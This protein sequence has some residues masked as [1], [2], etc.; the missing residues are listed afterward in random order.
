M[1][2][3]LAVIFL[4]PGYVAALDW[5]DTPSTA[6]RKAQEE[7]KDVLYLYTSSKM[8]EP[9]RLWLEA[10]QERNKDNDPLNDKF[11]VCPIELPDR[12]VMGNSGKADVV[13]MALKHGVNVVPT[14]V[15][16]DNS[17]R[18]YAKIP[19]GVM[20][21]EDVDKKVGVLLSFHNTWRELRIILEKS[22]STDDTELKHG[23]ILSVLEYVPPEFWKDSYPD[24]FDFLKTGNCESVLFEKALEAEDV[25]SSEKEFLELM[26][27]AAAEP[28]GEALNQLIVRFEELAGSKALSAD[29][30]QRILLA[31]VYPL[32]VKKAK[33]AYDG[34]TNAE[35]EEAFNK[36]IEILERIRD[37]DGTSSF[38]RQA[39][40]L[41]ETLRRARLS[42]AKYD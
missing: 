21:K 25:L 23:M 8:E 17:G 34:A 4:L 32:Y 15:L 13:Q 36:S 6:V 33:L 30:R 22:A 10:L 7:H 38:G 29:R 31:C 16:V 41:R 28:K 27:E 42:A 1:F 18:A 3:I 11:I 40:E 37:M 20:S 19:G 2:G 26:G 5:V 14:M 12:L 35:M 9:G 39:H 24:E